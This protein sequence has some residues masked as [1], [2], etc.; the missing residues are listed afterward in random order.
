MR[1]EP[2]GAGTMIGKRLRRV[3]S[4]FFGP[5][6]TRLRSHIRLMRKLQARGHV[7]AARFVARR[8]QSKF[9]VY[10]SPMATIPHSVRFVHPTGI[11]IGDGV[12]LGERVRVYQNVTLGGARIGDMQ[13]MNYPVIGDD[14]VIFAGAVI[15]GAV[16]IGRGCVIGANSVVLSDVPDGATAVGAPARVIQSRN[17]KV[18]TA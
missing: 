13:K 3:R 17:S 16:H 1:G 14:T 5:V 12:V 11:V 15:A 18:E 9:L 4:L 8:I 6:Q 7:R 10:I 2:E